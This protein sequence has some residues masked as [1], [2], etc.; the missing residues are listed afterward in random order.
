MT[1]SCRV[2]DFDSSKLFPRRTGIVLYTKHEDE[3]FFGFGRDSISHELTDFGGTAKYKSTTSKN[4]DKDAISAA[5][6][7]FHEETL[8]IFEDFPKEELDESLCL[9][10]KNNLVIFIRI[11]LNPDDIS[12][13]FNEKCKK[14]LEEYN[15]KVEVCGITWL[16]ISQFAEALYS[17]NYKFKTGILYYRIEKLFKN[18]NN[19]LNY[20]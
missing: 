4:L 6:R 2:R 5:I 3:I 16:S 18:A 8:F 19:F 13:K 20:I 12:Q 17:S 10:D 1:L 14:T 15:L 11:D 9:Y 7:E